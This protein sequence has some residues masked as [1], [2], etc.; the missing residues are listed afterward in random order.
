MSIPT[1]YLDTC[2]LIAMVKQDCKD[3]VVQTG[4]NELRGKVLD[5]RCKVVCSV[6]TQIEFFDADPDAWDFFDGQRGY[7]AA[8]SSSVVT[9]ATEIRKRCSV[10]ISSGTKT[11]T[12]Y[13]STTD[14]IHVATASIFSVEKLYTI[15]GNA[16][17]VDRNDNATILGVKDL[18][19]KLYGLSVACPKSDSLQGPLP[20]C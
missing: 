17:Q 10:S 15:D 4:V 16:K 14:A 5:G 1:F 3:P 18:L 6:A 13:L 2:V 8:I 7:R 19:R 9:L 11:K 20:N 12:C